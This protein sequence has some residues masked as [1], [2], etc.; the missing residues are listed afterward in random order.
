ML[1]RIL[2]DVDTS[3]A[4]LFF[5][6]STSSSINLSSYLN[7]LS[8]GTSLVENLWA[9]SYLVLRFLGSKSKLRQH[10]LVLV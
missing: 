3:L 7:P 5:I 1:L 8:L 6:L 2:R 4:L 10:I 9:L